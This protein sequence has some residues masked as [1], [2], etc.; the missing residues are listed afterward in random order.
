MFRL[1]G[2]QIADTTTLL[3]TGSA[4]HLVQQLEC[5]LGGTRIAVA[6]TQIRV[7]DSDQIELGKMVSLGHELRADHEIE[8]PPCHVV[9]FLPQTVDRFHQVARKHEYACLWKELGCFGFKTLDARPHR[10]E[11]L[12]G[13]AI[14]AFRGGRNGV[15]AV[16]THQPPLEPMI[17]QPGVAIRTVQA[18]A[19]GAAERQGG[20]TTP[21]EKQQ[22]LFASGER[23]GDSFGKEWWTETHG[24]GNGTLH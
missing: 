20:V 1:M 14:R 10:S 2:L 24:Q 11:A 19:A 23:N 21:I 5:P 6:K 22:R 9:E 12:G 7:D 8:S 16:V 4:N 13:V 15:S 18:K 17:D 3:P